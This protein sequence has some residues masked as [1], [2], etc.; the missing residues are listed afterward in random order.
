MDYNYV[1]KSWR[2]KYLGKIQKFCLSET[3]R[4]LYLSLRKTIK[5]IQKACTLDTSKFKLY[6][7]R[8]SKVALLYMRLLWTKNGLREKPAFLLWT[9]EN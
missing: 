7:A 4:N 5:I 6:N 3:I 1:E 9:Q 2:K 8:G